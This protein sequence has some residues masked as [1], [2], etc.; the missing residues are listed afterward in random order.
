MLVSA[1][2]DKIHQI[3]KNIIGN[4]ADAMVEDGVLTISCEITSTHLELH[5]QDNGPGVP[6]NQL[7]SIFNPFF[8]TKADGTG[9]GL[10]NARKFI[11]EMGGELTVESSPGSGALFILSIPLYRDDNNGANN[12]TDIS[13]R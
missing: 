8:T 1:D 2:K 12:E 3:V 9:L 5:F 13:S 10:A 4:S 11:Q 7:S 6:E